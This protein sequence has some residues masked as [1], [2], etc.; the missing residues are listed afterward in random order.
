MKQME[1]GHAELRKEVQITGKQ[2]HLCP[3]GPFSGLFVN[4]TL[5]LRDHS[6]RKQES[7]SYDTLIFMCKNVRLFKGF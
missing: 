2:E 6:G 7:R 5:C 3:L 4:W 1:K